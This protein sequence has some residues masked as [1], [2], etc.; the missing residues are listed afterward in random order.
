MSESVVGSIVSMWRYPVKSMLG[1]ELNATEV[2]ERGLMGDRAYAL[3]DAETGKIISAKLPRK[4]GVLFECR[5]AL[6][7]PTQVKIT[8]PDGSIVMGDRSD[9]NDILSEAFGRK[10]KL[11]TAAPAE[12]SIEMYTPDIEGIPDADAETNA[13]IRPN[14]FFDAATVH[15]LTTATLNQFQF[16][17]PTSR[18]EPR[19]FRPN[20]VIQPIDSATGF[21]ENDWVGKTLAI[22]DQV[23][24]SITEPCPRCVMTTMPQSE[25]PNDV[26][27]LRTIVKHNQGHVGIYASV[28]QG[29]KIRR[30]DRVAIV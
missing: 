5:A 10:V 17:Q 16:L 7:S 14:T 8:L 28:V 15:L 1:E 29:G 25:L 19:R 3:V 2:A 26:D 30:G 4:W 13:A 24:L 20:F 6:D 23:R 27:I 18:F 22:G 9:I 11:E 21:V 12:P